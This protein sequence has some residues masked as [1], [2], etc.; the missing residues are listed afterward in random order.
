MTLHRV[1]V[2]NCSPHSHYHSYTLE[3]PI[4]ACFQSFEKFDELYEELKM[5][6][7]Y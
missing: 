1:H 6:I 7:Y 5:I 4:K 3:Q 2:G